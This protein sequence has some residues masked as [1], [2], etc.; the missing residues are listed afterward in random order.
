MSLKMFVSGDEMLVC[1]SGPL[2]TAS[3]ASNA[4]QML[5]PWSRTS[6]GV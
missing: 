4:F 1:H 6:V 2:R 5:P 3:I